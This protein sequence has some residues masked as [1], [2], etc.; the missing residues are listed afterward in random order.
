MVE[1]TCR[2]C[3]HGYGAHMNLVGCWVPVEPR[4][5]VFREVL[6]NDHGDITT[7]PGTH[8]CLCTLAEAVWVEGGDAAKVSTE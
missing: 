6:R 3:G 7:R 1:P 4:S 2:T 5:Y 8:R